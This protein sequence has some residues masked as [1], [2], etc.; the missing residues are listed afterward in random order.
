MTEE[1]FVCFQ[2]GTHCW[3]Q[4][5]KKWV[6]LL[7]MPWQ[8]GR[9]NLWGMQKANRGQSG[10]CSGQAMARWGNHSVTI[11]NISLFRRRRSFLFFILIINNIKLKLNLIMHT[12]K[13]CTTLYLAA[14][15]H[16]V[17][18]Q[19]LQLTQSLANSVK[20]SGVIFQNEHRFSAN[21]GK[22]VLCH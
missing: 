22:A 17:T 6:V 10:E 9:T 19:F 11:H 12:L 2:E 20:C 1:W 21:L 4:G 14:L 7:A 8:D 3:C 5:A 16:F 15:Q 13:F 18:L